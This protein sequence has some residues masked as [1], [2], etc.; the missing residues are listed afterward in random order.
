MATR[1]EWDELQYYNKENQDDNVKNWERK[2]NDTG[3]NDDGEDNAT[4]HFTA[5]VALHNW[6]R[7]RSP[8]PCTFHHT[9]IGSSWVLPALH[10]ITM[11]IHMVVSLWLDLLHS[12]LLSLLLSVFFFPFFH[13]SD[14]QQPE[15]N[16]KIMENLRDSANKGVRAPTTSSTS[17]HIACCDG[18]TRK[19]KT[20]CVHSTPVHCIASAL[21][22]RIA[23]R[24]GVC[25]DIH[26]LTR[27]EQEEGTI[28]WLIFR[29]T[30]IAKYADVRKLRERHA[31]E[32]LTIG[33]TELKLLKDLVMW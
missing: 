26:P 15:L 6:A 13:L 17:P 28:Y 18:R 25:T 24:E 5:C 30:R 16:K 9:H 33:R 12:L 7:A 27:T 4:A 10:S 2:L 14:E 3:A 1:N 32:I 8:V 23:E 20:L 22:E 31:Q 21:R 11:V 29:K 19:G